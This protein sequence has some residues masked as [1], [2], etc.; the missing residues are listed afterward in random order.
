MP[1]ELD[2]QLI[3]A[4]DSLLLNKNNALDS[5]ALIKRLLIGASIG[6]ND[7]EL[8]KQFINSQ[9]HLELNASLVL[10]T[11][12]SQISNQLITDK[13]QPS[14][15]LINQ[16]SSS[17]ILL[18][19]LL[20]LHPQ[21]QDLFK[22][23]YNLRILLK[24]LPLALH[25]AAYSSIGLPLLDLLL[26]T[27]V[28]SATNAQLFESAGGLEILVQAMKQ[29]SLKTEL[30]VKVLEAL[31]AWWIDE[32]DPA[33]DTHPI[34]PPINHP[35]Q[36][37]PNLDSALP[38]PNPPN[39]QDHPKSSSAND[40]HQTPS[41]KSRAN[42]RIRPISLPPPSLSE[43]DELANT[44]GNLSDGH[45]TPKANKLAPKVRIQPSSATKPISRSQS[46]LPQQPPSSSHSSPMVKSSSEGSNISATP[47]RASKSSDPASRLRMML[48]NT[49]G[50]F[51][52][53]TPHHPHR[54]RPAAT[55]TSTP[56][57][58]SSSPSR[59]VPL[60]KSHP[61]SLVKNSS[62]S[63]DQQRT[64]GGRPSESSED[65]DMVNL[66]PNKL[67]GVRQRRTAIKPAS[68]TPQRLI[69]HKQSASLGSI[70]HQLQLP[71]KAH[72]QSSEDEGI[73]GSGSADSEREGA[74]RARDPTRR[75]I[76]SSA[77]FTPEPMASTDTPRRPSSRL[78]QA[79]TPHI[80]P[81][82][83]RKRLSCDTPRATRPSAK[84]PSR[85][86]VHLKLTPQR[87][88]SPAKAGSSSSSS[89]DELMIEQTPRRALSPIKLSS[90][91]ASASM[92]ASNKTLITPVT[93]TSSKHNNLIVA[94]KLNPSSTPNKKFISKPLS[95]VH[96]RIYQSDLE[97]IVN[98]TDSDVR[99]NPALFS[100]KKDKSKHRRSVGV[101]KS[102]P[103]T[104]TPPDDDDDY[105]CDEKPLPTTPQQEPESG[106]DQLR[107]PLTARPIVGPTPD[108]LKQSVGTAQ[109]QQRKQKKTGILEKYMA[110]SDELVRSFR[111]IG[112]GFKA[113]SRHHHH[114][115]VGDGRRG[116]VGGRAGGRDDEEPEIVERPSSSTAKDSELP[117]Q[118]QQ[119]LVPSTRNFQPLVGP[120]TAHENKKHLLHHKMVIKDKIRAVKGPGRTEKFLPPRTGRRKSRVVS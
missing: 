110:N 43:E 82:S 88:A 114:H 113:L 84:T 70:Q 34:L 31:W 36:S 118:Q 55:A 92:T 24:F 17:F 46:S 27:F 72:S 51:V 6:G 86:S 99:P 38:N 81:S 48:E 89:H 115:P 52:P 11:S 35:C 16:L 44:S 18:Q 5:L 10:L 39:H 50:Q 117:S 87:P 105:A 78:T 41:N 8:G 1:E 3:R 53:A 37:P 95:P 76:R 116:S 23:E 106:E 47:F 120:N 22:S 4:Y 29:K 68:N 77:T 112:V 30:R 111:E 20:H 102:T 101:K 93:P 60:H 12:I 74:Q 96:A 62:D 64:S 59:A 32:D 119:Q 97:S 7:S 80:V 13:Q 104:T 21:S 100:N 107:S 19:G 49:A 9:N 83:E 109:H 57:D 40:H 73:S 85:N 25:S 65:S 45:E 103:T 42:S 91:R 63:D 2:Q 67:F 71:T 28:D 33:P 15:A 56:R 69:R 79:T 26:M 14:T 98:A 90:S 108:V 66:S 94:G 75:P 61:V 58:H 54:T